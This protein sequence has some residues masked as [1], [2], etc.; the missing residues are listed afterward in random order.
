MDRARRQQ[1]LSVALSC[2]A[3]ALGCADEE[4]AQS[5]GNDAGTVPETGAIDAQRKPAPKIDAQPDVAPKPCP[6]SAPCVLFYGPI[7]FDADPTPFDST[8]YEPFEKPYLPAGSVVSIADAEKWSAM[9]KADFAAFN[10]V[11]IGDNLDWHPHPEYLESAFE[12]RATWNA[13]ISGRVVAQGIDA[14]FHTV[15]SE[16]PEGAQAYL[17]QIFVWLTEGQ[18]TALYVSSIARD[19]DYLSG[20]GSFATTFDEGD[21]V[22]FDDPTHPIFAHSTAASLSNWVTT[23]HR[24]ASSFP[25]DFKSLARAASGNPIVLARN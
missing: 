14:G 16:N 1:E 15:V 25:S 20:V 7:V 19:W 17:R 22:T 13:A 6:S 24:S 3:L 21:S 4:P 8:V 2:V 12:N 5:M 11:I 9:T 10:L 23:Y 18:G